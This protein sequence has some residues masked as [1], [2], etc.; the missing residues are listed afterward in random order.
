[1]N[2]TEKE[3]LDKTLEEIGLSATE[4]TFYRSVLQ[5]KEPLVAEIV[6]LSGLQ[7]PTAYQALKKLKH[8][9]LLTTDTKRYNQRV[10][11]ISPTKLIQLV[12]KKQRD[13]R[14]LELKLKEHQSALQKSF[15]SSFY[16][17]VVQQF[18]GTEKY[19]ELGE[20]TLT[21][22]SKVIRYLGNI[23]DYLEVVGEEYDRN[24]YLP[25]RLARGIR[26]RIICNEAP[27]LAKIGV[28]DAE[29]MRERKVIPRTKFSIDS[30]AALFDQTVIFYSKPEEQLA[31]VVTSSSIVSL[32][33]NLFDELWKKKM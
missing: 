3:L 21:C 14:K 28:R 2:T 17:S 1:M 13:I 15:H 32:L 20:L 29:E 19:R 33:K 5:S 22:K 12:S 18:E 11:A 9:G 30:S 6:K 25:E 16:P 7:R 4:K 27:Y 10:T 8:R 24:E 31:L 23:D 26:L